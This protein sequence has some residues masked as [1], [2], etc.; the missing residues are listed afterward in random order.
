MYD[1][2]TNKPNKNKKIVFGIVAVMSVVLVGI[3]VFFMFGGKYQEDVLQDYFTHVEKGEYDQLV[4]LVDVDSLEAYG[5][6]AFVERNKNIYEGIEAK[7]F[8]VEIGEKESKDGNDYISYQLKMTTSIGKVTL[9]NTAIFNGDK[10]VWNDAFIFPDLKK[11]YKVRITSSEASRGQI[12]DTNGKVLAGK[13]EAYSVGLV[14]GKLNGE[15][16]YEKIGKILGLTRESIQKTMSASWIKDDSF[17][18]LKTIAKDST[19]ETALLAIPGVKLTSSSVRY[20]PYGKIT[21]HLI[22]YMQ[23][24]TAEDLEKHKG[25]GYTETSSIGKSGIE[26]AYEKQLKGQ[27]GG[28]IFIVDS[29]K[30]EVSTIVESEKKNGQDIALTIDIDLQKSLYNEYQDRKSASVALNPKTGEVLALVST[31]SFSSNDFIYGFSSDAWKALNDDASQPLA[32]RFKGTYVP[33]SCM[34]P[35]TAAIGLNSGKLDTNKDFSAAMSWQKD[36][37]WGSYKVTTLHAPNPNNLK[38]ALVYSDNVYFAKVALEI[39]KDALEK[40]YKSLKIGEEIPFE[41]SLSKSQYTSGSF[42]KDIQIADSGYGQG[43]ILMNPLQMA[44]IYGGFINDGNIMT[45]YVVKGTESKAWISNAFSKET[46]NQIKDDL[47]AVVSDPNGTAHGIYQSNVGLAGKTGTG[48]VKASQDDTTGTEMGWFTVMTTDSKKPFVLTT[49][50]EDV[51]GQGGSTYI[52]N[53]SKN[54]LNLYLNK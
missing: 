54:S 3:A 41:L 25:E 5:K 50:V 27:N 47:T 26:A 43:E 39:G 40:G 44:S 15:S 46:A 1:V 23:K 13:G 36:S 7:D 51:K 2:Y 49:M 28:R 20:Y 14:K 21:S 35:I 24:V 8:N 42:D 48:E 38:N 10:I 11:D 34:K 30:K 9:D 18:P 6:D 12:L 37:S 29:N 22:G 45:P 32:N 19:T 33:G 53:H 16:D 4:D 17:V 31:P 52:V